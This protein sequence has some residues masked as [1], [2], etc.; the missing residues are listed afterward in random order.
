MQKVIILSVLIVTIF[1][2]A[3]GAK[4]EAAVSQT[5]DKKSQQTLVE[6]NKEKE[7]SRI[8]IYIG[9]TLLT[10]TLNN[11]K[12][13]QDFIDSL[14][15]TLI[16]SKLYDREYY[17]TLA[18]SLSS[19]GAQQNEYDVGDIAYWPSRGYFGILYSRNNPK[20]NS[21]I[22]VLGK[23]TDNVHALANMGQNIEVKIE[24]VN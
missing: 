2:S 14:P 10:A 20:M 21:P 16:M 6:K 19:D 3:C 18:K 4:E 22:I 1:T 9:N 8:N 15:Q 13:A 5:V 24:L 17:T 23:V 7:T 12:A 11:S